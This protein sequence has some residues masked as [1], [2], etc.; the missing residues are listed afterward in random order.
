MSMN[1]NRSN[2]LSVVRLPV[3]AILSRPAGLSAAGVRQR[4][5]IISK[6]RFVTMANRHRVVLAGVEKMQKAEQQVYSG[7]KM[8]PIVTCEGQP[9][10]M[11]LR[12]AEFRPV[13]GPF[14]SIPF[15]SVFGK[16]LCIQLGIRTCKSCKMSLIVSKAVE[17]HALRCPSCFNR[18]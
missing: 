5:R 14:E 2:A 18:L 8:L 13:Q 10:F 12:L 17:E 9:L 3:L 11:D 6:W 4:R 15:G 7:P 16:E 1:M